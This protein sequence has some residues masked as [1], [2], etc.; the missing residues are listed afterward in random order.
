MTKPTRRLIF[1][2]LVLVFILVGS[3]VVLY[4]DGWRIDFGS[5]EARKVGAIFVRSFPSDALI[6]LNNRPVKNGS[7]LLGSGT[8]VNNLFPKTYELKLTAPGYE[9]WRERIAVAPS[10]VSEVKHAVLIP[11][12]PEIALSGETQSFWL[13]DRTLLVED[14]TGALAINGKTI[15]RGE[16]LGWTRNGRKLLVADAKGAT[17]LYDLPTGASSSV[18][19]LLRRAGFDTR[20]KFRVALDPEDE[21]ALIVIEPKRLSLLTIAQARLTPLASLA[22]TSS[23]TFANIA[24]SPF[25]LAWTTSDTKGATS[26]LFVYDKVLGNFL[27]TPPPF[28][29]SN[30]ALAWGANNLVGVL[31]DDGELYIYDL[32]KNELQKIADD[33]K[34]F[35]FSGDG[36]KVA[37]L[38]HRAL[39]V[40]S[41]AHKEDY[42]K[43]ALPEMESVRQVIWYTDD[44]HLFVVYAGS[45]AFL[46]L[47]DLGQEN[48][49]TVAETARTEY[50]P[51][52]NRLYFLKDGRL[53]QLEFPS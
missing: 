53:M 25:S 5:F 1:Y 15:G 17:A 41:F 21:G 40:F 32:N 4:A 43:F 52:S 29:G 36:T 30:A 38:E 3:G 47:N 39:E 12:N 34:D 35:A 28:P 19:T 23:A 18:P 46:D 31:Q 27:P 11:K 42:R 20:K 10:L 49:T 37:A 16:V 8:F 7:W 26:T 50:D 14:A 44:E 9:D 48:V 6:F 24:A 51:K 2:A 13:V 22:P 45:V 33:V